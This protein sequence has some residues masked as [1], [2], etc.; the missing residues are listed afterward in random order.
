MQLFA[1]SEFKQENNPVTVDA[2]WGVLLP[3]SDEA[4]EA[5]SALRQA[6]AV[7]R[8]QEER[9]RLL[10]K[11]ALTDELTGL[12]NRRAF[13]AA[14][15][16]ELAL[17]Q[18]DSNCAG[19][20]VMIDLDGFKQINDSWGHQVGDTYLSTV[21]QVLKEQ[22]RSTDVVGR[23]GGDEFAILLINMDEDDGY[24]R[25]ERLERAFNRSSLF[26]KESIPLRA[27]F[28]CAAYGNGLRAEQVIEA[29]DIRLYAHK[30]RNKT[31]AYI[32]A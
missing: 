14:F 32:K 1:K 6:Q 31:P 21:A 17:A 22:V 5:R 27:S 3:L 26:L 16:R 13:V 29:A 19:V 28:G 7:I 20:L 12:A 23:L 25:V 2:D 10:E 30:A 24:A 8:A 15:D 18:R 9:I 4:M 11:M